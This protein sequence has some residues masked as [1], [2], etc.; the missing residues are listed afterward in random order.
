MIF[1]VGHVVNYGEISGEIRYF[2]SEDDAFKYYMQEAT[3]YVEKVGII[4]ETLKLMELD[5]FNKCKTMK[6]L[7]M[8][9]DER[10]GFEVKKDRDY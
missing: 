7:V 8:Y 6:G 9:T 4:P 2:T 5:D 10:N 1:A 3:K